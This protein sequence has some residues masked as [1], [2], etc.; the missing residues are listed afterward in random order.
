VKNWFQNLLSNKWV[1]HLCR[2]SLVPPERVIEVD[3]PGLSSQNLSRFDWAYLPRPCWPL[4]R[5]DA[6][7]AANGN[8]LD[9]GML[10]S[11]GVAEDED[12]GEDEGDDEDEGGDGGGGGSAADIGGGSAC[13][14]HRWSASSGSRAGVLQ[15]LWRPRRNGGLSRDT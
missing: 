1:F 10:L 4:D 6:A 11:S 5:E 12:G 13:G 8:H 14:G 2:Y 15:V 7:F 3:A 9:F